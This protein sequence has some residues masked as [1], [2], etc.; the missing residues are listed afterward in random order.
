M[1]IM[2]AEPISTANFINPSHQSVS[3]CVFFIVARQRLGENV[4]AETNIRNNRRIF[5]RIVL[6]PVR[7]VSR[8]VG[9]LFFPELLVIN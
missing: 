4:T 5:G 9:D 2:A 3:V 8:K 6:Y 7:V 1:Y